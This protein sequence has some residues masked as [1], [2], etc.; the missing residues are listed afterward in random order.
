M[1]RGS[2]S[3]AYAIASNGG[4]ATVDDDGIV[5]IDTTEALDDAL[6]VVRMTDGADVHDVHLRVTTLAS[7]AADHQIASQAEFDALTLA[8]GD[9]VE[10]TARIDSL[11]VT[12]SGFVLRSANEAASVGQVSFSGT[13]SGVTL[14]HLSVECRAW[15][16]FG[17]DAEPLRFTSG[18]VSDL[19]VEGCRIVALQEGA[20]LW[21]TGADS[22]VFDVHRFE[23]TA[24]GTSVTHVVP[25]D[26]Q[27][28]TTIDT[29]CFVYRPTGEGSGTLTVEHLDAQGNVLAFRT[30]ADADQSN[31]G[32]YL[33]A[34]GH[35][36]SMRV[37]SDA[38]A[39]GY[40]LK[41]FQFTDRYMADMLR[42]SPGHG[43]TFRENWASGFS[44]AVKPTAGGFGDR[45]L[46]RQNVVTATFQ[47]LVAGGLNGGDRTLRVQGNLFQ[48]AFTRG[49][50]LQIEND[51][52]PGDPHSDNYQT[53]GTDGASPNCAVEI[54]GNTTV[55]GRQRPGGNPGI[56][57]NML[58]QHGGAHPEYAR[59]LI[60]GNYL[61]G[62][63]KGVNGRATEMIAAGNVAWNAYA[64]PGLPAALD[65]EALTNPGGIAYVHGT[66]APIIP[67]SA[68]DRRVS[69]SAGLGGDAAAW[70]AAWDG[71]S[72]VGGIVDR[73]SADAAFTPAAG[74]AAAGM[75]PVGADLVDFSD[76]S[77]RW[78]RIPAAA[79]FPALTDVAA[80]AM[81]ESAV[82]RM[83]VGDVARTIAPEAGVE[84]RWAHT[85]TEVGLE[86][87]RS[88]A[89][90]VL[91]QPGA[92][93]VF[94]Q[95]RHA[96][97]A[98]ELTT[99]SLGLTEGGAVVGRLDVTTAQTSATILD[100]AAIPA[101]AMVGHFS[102]TRSDTPS[103]HTITASGNSNGRAGY[104][105]TSAVTVGETYRVRLPVWSD[106][107]RDVSFAAAR[108]PQISSVVSG[109]EITASVGDDPSNPTVVELVFTPDSAE[110]YVGM[111][112]MGFAGT[113]TVVAADATLARV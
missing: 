42:G 71:W 81:A 104:D 80:S 46:I 32:R 50:S 35:T 62:G 20:A 52:D 51:Y 94:V 14:R 60:A 101:S 3:E 84:W 64:P 111:R 98:S 59:I 74:G 45:T 107:P 27:A 41:V 44:N 17:L 106:V 37:T 26:A 30:Y 88:G 66:V 112:G 79:A 56:M 10:V 28:D 87:W 72:T 67:E 108:N 36:R 85:E 92:L 48:R 47:D 113:V 57:Q 22:Y 11:T 110:T 105:I 6:L 109:S 100:F 23:G 9:V 12:G 19:T 29:G 16:V 38:A 8:P 78:D 43:F 33:T 97:S 99:T 91:A 5:S 49:S 96:A 21:D 31:A 82:M 69:R 61:S 73:Q 103:R 93:S 95:V 13:A 68:A 40:V 55:L 76:F 2:G 15:P 58:L 90:D 102:I 63:S 89:D 83:I 39:T 77:V 7:P 4:F 86:A 1:P 25:W 53:F 75:G 34:P 65:V 70:A 54:V 24:S 18:T